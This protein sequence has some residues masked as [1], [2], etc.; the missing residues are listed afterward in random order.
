MNKN[1]RQQLS[2]KNDKLEE[3][4]AD[5]EMLRDEEQDY[6]DNMPE[7]LQSGGKGQQAEEA[8]YEMDSAILGIEEAISSIKNA[9][10]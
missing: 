2:E 3:I 1:R 9:S 10:K 7:S 8:I 6:H 4:K 5:I